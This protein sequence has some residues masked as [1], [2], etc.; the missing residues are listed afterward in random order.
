MR[1]MDA[2]FLAVSSILNAHDLCETIG[3]SNGRERGPLL[4]IHR[5]SFAVYEGTQ[6]AGAT[7]G[8]FEAM[9]RMEKAE[10]RYSSLMTKEDELRLEKVI[11]VPFWKYFNLKKIK[12][13]NDVLRSLLVQRTE[14]R[15][16]CLNINSRHAQRYV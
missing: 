4:Y 12:Q 16:T 5:N 13:Q 9:V 7:T 10:D 3:G 8:F 15:M 2:A 6:F 1:L 11:D 14:K